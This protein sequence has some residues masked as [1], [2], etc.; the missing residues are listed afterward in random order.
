MDQAQEISNRIF[1]LVSESP[2]KKMLGVRLGASLRAYFPAFQPANFRCRNLRHFISA[3]VPAVY[4]GGRSGADLVYTVGGIGGNLAAAAPSLSDAPD[5]NPEYVRLPVPVYVW[6]AYSN[7]S[8]PFV[9]AVNRDT[10]A[11]QTLAEGRQVLSPWIIVPKPNSDFHLETANEFVSSQ[12]E[13]L[14]TNLGALLHDPKWY[15]RFST[16]ATRNGLG[17]QWTAFR[18]ARLVSSFKS[19]LQSLSI[20][21]APKFEP[22]SG[23]P[24]AEAGTVPEIQPTSA[25]DAEI[26]FRNLVRRVVMELP[27]EELR[28]LRLPVGAVVDALTSRK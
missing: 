26:E 19:F 11:V 5:N 21:A 14:R 28:L 18:R 7:P 9:V 23:I 22:N 17:A 4:E 27:L 25:N 13:P 10:G 8:E 1:Q 16:V 2:D 12:P 6:K 20:P 24:A 3:F 15:V